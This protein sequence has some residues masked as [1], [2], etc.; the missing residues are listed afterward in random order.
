MELVA[1]RTGQV[2]NET[3]LSRQCAVSQPT[4]HRYVN[5]LEVT[6]LIRRLPAYTVNRGKRIAKRPKLHVADV[7]LA[8]F[9]QGLHT[10]EEVRAAREFGAL[11]E[12]L[13]V[14]HLGVLA[15]LLSPA[16]RLFHWRTSDGKEVDVVL[17]HG[18]SLVAFECK[19]TRRPLASHARHLRLFRELH[20]EC[21][22]GVL[23][24]AGDRV[25]HLGAGVVALPWALL[26]GADEPAT[27]R[28]GLQ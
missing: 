10:P 7:G 4:V 28:P 16:A 3:R 5:L 26:A 11:F 19:A 20:P 21:R 2:V 24:H 27:S 23:V 9:L 13:V 22:A 18:R 12:G 6:L 15:S 17:S 8:A 1:V 25:E 14:H